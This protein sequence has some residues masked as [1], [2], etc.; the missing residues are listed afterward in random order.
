[1]SADTLL[2]MIDRAGLV[3]GGALCDVAFR[4]DEK[5]G[6]CALGLNVCHPLCWRTF[7]C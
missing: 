1:M 6:L 4:K 7:E 3:P 5:Q 2:S